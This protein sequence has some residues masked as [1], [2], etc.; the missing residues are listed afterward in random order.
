MSDLHEP[1]LD[2][3]GDL[4]PTHVE[5]DL[6]RLVENHHAIADHVQRPVM[7]ILKANAYG[8]GLVPVAKALADAGAPYLGVAYL[9]EGIMLRRAGVTAPIL[10]LGGIIGSQIPS[11]L[12]HDLTLCASSEDKLY[13]IEE[14]AAHAKIRA[15]VHLKIDTG[16]ERIGVHWYSAE[17]LLKATLRTKNVRVEGIFSHLSCADHADPTTT[18]LQIERFAEVCDFYRR[19][20]LPTP[21]RH[22]A[23]SAAIIAHADAW[24]DLVRPGILS[25]GVYPAPNLPRVIPVQPALSWVSRV[26]YF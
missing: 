8:H 7:P 24:L 3:E 12:A 6:Q 19:R 16:M 11:F 10:V 4:R 25:F 23:N 13:A 5:V 1:T 2:S 26:V 9:E 20:G 15:K 14:A 22:L 18:R 21:T 17:P